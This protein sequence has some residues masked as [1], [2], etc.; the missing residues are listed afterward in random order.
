[1][2]WFSIDRKALQIL[3]TNILR[4]D[5]FMYNSIRFIC[6]YTHVYGSYLLYFEY[7]TVLA[8]SYVMQ[9]VSYLEVTLTLA[10]VHVLLWFNLF[11]IEH[12]E[13]PVRWSE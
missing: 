5:T 11:S 7:A 2:L 4:L 12:T 8:T 10:P 1:M 13:V 9:S 6:I 3:Y